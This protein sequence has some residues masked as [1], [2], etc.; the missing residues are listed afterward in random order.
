MRGVNKAASRSQLVGEIGVNP[1]KKV[2]NSFIVGLDLLP[3]AYW[4]PVGEVDEFSSPLIIRQ[5]K[6]QPK[7]QFAPFCGTPNRGGIKVGAKRIF[8]TDDGSPLPEVEDIVAA[9][10]N[11]PLFEAVGELR[12]DRRIRLGKVRTLKFHGIGSRVGQP[13]R[14]VPMHVHVVMKLVGQ[15][16]VTERQQRFVRGIEGQPLF[17]FADFAVHI[18]KIVARLELKSFP[19]FQVQ[20]QLQT[21]A[22]ACAFKVLD[23]RF[24]RIG[25]V[26]GKDLILKIGAVKVRTEIP[27]K[28]FVVGFELLREVQPEI[29]GLFGLQGLGKNNVPG[30]DEQADIFAEQVYGPPSCSNIR[31]NDRLGGDVEFHQGPW[32]ELHA[33]LIVQIAPD[34]GDPREF[35]IEK[36]QGMLCKKARNALHPPIVAG[37]GPLQGG[38]GKSNV[39]VQV[40]VAVADPRFEIISRII[41]FVLQISVNIGLLGIV[42]DRPEIGFLLLMKGGG[43]EH[44]IVF[45][46]DAVAGFGPCLRLIDADGLSIN[47]RAPLIGFGVECGLPAHAAFVEKTNPD[48]A[49]PTKIRVLPINPL[50]GDHVASEFG[51]IQKSIVVPVDGCCRLHGVKGRQIA[52]IPLGECEVGIEVFLKKTV[53]VGI[54]QQ[55]LVGV[56]LDGFHV[57]LSADAFVALQHAVGTFG[58]INVVDHGPGNA[59]DAVSVR[60]SLNQ[61][62]PVDQN[63]IVNARQSQNAEFLGIG[64]DIGGLRLHGRL[65]FKTT[66]EVATGGFLQFGLGDLLGFDGGFIGNR[67]AIPLRFD[68]HIVQGFGFLQA[69]LHKGLTGN[70]NRI[71]Q[72]PD[73]TC[74]E[75]LG[76]NSFG[77]KL[78]LPIAARGHPD[79]RAHPKHRCPREGFL[80]FIGD[81]AG[82]VLRH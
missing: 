29:E 82:N 43:K 47:R 7:I 80:F 53:D 56:G 65:G 33:K 76:D 73:I 28:V 25:V 32:G 61:R 39:L 2:S 59:A 4:C 5:P 36:P 13:L 58:D 1:W 60:Q 27:G 52:P 34:A 72:V 66:R 3:R 70:R 78:K 81:L 30:T 50:V 22:D 21:I 24:R 68:Q 74:N 37:I 15:G 23:D 8:P 55:A 62:K 49:V 51:Q 18:Q 9:C 17:G 48:A 42:F 35:V 69:K 12:I 46:V 20:F 79:F 71:R 19:N 67:Y 57:D 40:E 54:E 44:N 77:R 26:V 14:A 11:F 63:L 45:F 6:P 31:P 75:F 41:Q 16:F 10:V 64:D 38:I